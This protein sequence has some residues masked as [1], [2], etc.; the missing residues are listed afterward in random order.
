MDRSRRLWG[1][2]V[3]V[4]ALLSLLAVGPRAWGAPAQARPGQGFTV[5]TRTPVVEWSPTLRPT[6]R[7]QATDIPPT[8]GPITDP[9]PLPPATPLPGATP[10][11]ASTPVPSA[12]VKAGPGAVL[13]LINEV[14][15]REAWPGV[16]VNYT[17]MLTNNG[18]VSARQVLVEDTLPDG[19]TGRRR[20][21]GE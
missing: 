18:S 19:L 17:L 15:R 10:T 2:G 1:Y 20:A 8:E 21:R 5:P 9:T 4:L 3:T 6:D 13:A 12:T 16:T 11:L 7:P 14:A